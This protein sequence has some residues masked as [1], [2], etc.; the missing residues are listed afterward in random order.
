MAQISMYFLNIDNHNEAKYKVLTVVDNFTKFGFAFDV[1]SENSLNL[2]KLLYRHVYS[3]FGIP[4][5]V[6]TDQGKSFLAKVVQDLNTMLEI[7]RP[8]YT[9]RNPMELVNA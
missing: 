4:L 3:K 8:Q 7:Q 5:V 2:A 9:N 6:H 1:K